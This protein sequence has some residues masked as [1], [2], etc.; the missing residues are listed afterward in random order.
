[1]NY[2]VDEFT[3]LV[4][5]LASDL[6][7]LKRTQLVDME[8]LG[9]PIPDQA[10]KKDIANKLHMYHLM[11]HRLHQLDTHTGFFLLNNALSLP[12]LLF[13]LRSFQ[14][15]RNS[16][17]LTPYDE[18]TRDT[19]VSIC[20]VQ[21]DDAGWKHSKLPARFGGLRLRSND[22]ALTACLSSRES[23]RRLTSTITHH[24]LSF[25]SKTQT[26]SLR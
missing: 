19:A 12:R 5:T 9:S 22:L 10:V 25:R 21:F 24:Y 14:C 3:K 2:P 17:D 16:D 6:P 7:G 11:T 23:C 18:C 8:L 26:M 4:R 13:L 20:N 15:Y 1:M